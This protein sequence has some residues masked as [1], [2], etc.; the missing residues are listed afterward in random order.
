[1]DI[2]KLQIRMG[3]MAA[4]IERLQSI[5]VGERTLKDEHIAAERL[6]FDRIDGL[7]AEREQL[8]AQVN[9]QKEKLLRAQNHISE[10]KKDMD[11][12]HTVFVN[13]RLDRDDLK[14]K[15]RNALL[16][17]QKSE[18][19]PSPAVA[20]PDPHPLRES[21]SS[22]HRSYA[23][24]FNACREKVLSAMTSPRITEQDAP[25]WENE[26]KRAFWCGLEI[27]AGMGSVAIL[28]RWNEYI[29]KRKGELLNKLNAK[30]EQP[31]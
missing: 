31:K 11:L 14:E 7:T 27:G 26:A 18:A 10:L 8:L 22:N 12:G 15:L 2:E 5:I 29:A 30:Q 17:L 28:P 23:E 1:M 20:A 3:E 13:T 21:M 4:E 19:Q 25:D 24:G 16:Y 9:R 6:L